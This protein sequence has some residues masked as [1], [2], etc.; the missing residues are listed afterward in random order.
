MQIL[1]VLL[2]YHSGVD[3][4]ENVCKGIVAFIVVWLKQPTTFVVQAIPHA[5]QVNP[6]VTFNGQWLTEKI[7]DNTD[8]LIEIGLSVRSIVTG[9]HSANVNAFSALKIFNSESNCCIKH[10]QNSTKIYL[11]YGT[12]HL[13][14]NIRNR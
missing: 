10:P 14:K 1:S 11:F 7:S 6:E 9:N 4:E 12:V 13:M 2:Q 8:S 3:K 5:S